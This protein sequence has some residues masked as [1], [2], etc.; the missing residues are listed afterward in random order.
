[1]KITTKSVAAFTITDVEGVDAITV[2]LENF[3]PEVGPAGYYKGKITIECYGQ[4]WSNYWGSMAE[5]TIQRF[6]VGAWPEYLVN[7]LDNELDKY[8]N[9]WEEISDILKEDV[10]HECDLALYEDKLVETWGD[11]W[12]ECLPKKSNPKFMYLIRIVETV[13]KALKETYN[14]E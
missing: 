14:Y 12:W 3:R 7:K 5:P 6:F 9:D 4:A 13:Q 11:G 2:Y 8:I 10:N 1:M